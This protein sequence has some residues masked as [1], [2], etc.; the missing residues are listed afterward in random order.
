MFKFSLQK[1]ENTTASLITIGIVLYSVHY[2]L[3]TA[4]SY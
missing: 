1:Q 4:I 3:Y 2:K